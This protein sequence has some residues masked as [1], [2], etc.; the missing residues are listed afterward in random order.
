[1]TQIDAEQKLVTKRGFI[2]TWLL[3]QLVF[4]VIAFLSFR[5]I[6]MSDTRS[7]SYDAFLFAAL[8][9]FPPTSFMG[10][11]GYKAALGGGTSKVIFGLLS[12][13][14]IGGVV[15]FS[16]LV[17]VSVTSGIWL[18]VALPVFLI[19]RLVKLIKDTENAFAARRA[20]RAKPRVYADEENTNEYVWLTP[21]SPNC[22][23]FALRELDDLHDYMEQQVLH[24]ANPLHPHPTKL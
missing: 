3:A 10:L 6:A 17:P 5:L 23:S 13:A 8:I 2:R 24:E 15:F 21:N 14:S 9:V 16:D 20:E 11:W 22:K 12:V 7:L 1:M 19:T 18:A 4:L